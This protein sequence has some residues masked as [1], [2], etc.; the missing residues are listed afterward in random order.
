MVTR[1]EVSLDVEDNRSPYDW[2]SV[3]DLTTDMLQYSVHFPLVPQTG[4]WPDGSPRRISSQR[5]PPQ[6]TEV[7]RVLNIVVS[8]SRV[9]ASRERCPFLVRMEVADTCLEGSDARLYASGAS[10]LGSTL[11]EALGM[12]S[13][14]SPHPQ[15]SFPQPSYEI[16]EELVGR[17]SESNPPADRSSSVIKSEGGEK[18]FPRGGWQDHENVLGGEERVGY[19]YPSSYDDVR[20][21]EY[22]RLHHQMQAQHQAP[23]TPESAMKLEQR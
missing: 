14:S 15:S 13:G 16:P 3:Q 21:Q 1:G 11:E 23:P 4:T 10:D 8:E 5:D 12:V 6:S 9:L 18:V 7:V 2:P 22:E 20:Q 19:M 17:G